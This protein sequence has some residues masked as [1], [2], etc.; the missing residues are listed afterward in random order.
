MNL[1]E[2]AWHGNKGQSGVLL[3]SN[4]N[5][6]CKTIGEVFIRLCNERALQHLIVRE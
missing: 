1:S 6:M 4:N 2:I 3:E 5:P